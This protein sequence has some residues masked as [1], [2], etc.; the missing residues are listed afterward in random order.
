MEDVREVMAEVRDWES[1]GS[2]LNVPYSKRQEIMQQSSTE[3]EKCLAVGDYWV[4]TDPDAS[5]E[6]LA[7][8]LYQSQEEKALAVVKQY[9]QQQGMCSS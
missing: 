7:W 9:L 8:V 2:W 1:V 4:N 5:W 6:R 3:R